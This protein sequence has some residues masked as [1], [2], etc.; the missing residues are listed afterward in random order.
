MD[1][2]SLEYIPIEFPA[3]ADPAMVY[4]LSKQSYSKG[5]KAYQGIILSNDVFY[6]KYS[7]LFPDFLKKKQG[8]IDA[9][10][11]SLDNESSALFIIGY[12]RNIRIGSILTGTQSLQKNNHVMDNE[13]ENLYFHQMTEI[14]LETFYQFKE[15]DEY[16]FL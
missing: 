13:K 11:L 10:I 4:M 2:T 7:P 16:S 9:Q 8:W 14:C 6:Q 12:I 3:I 5:L 1:G 15:T